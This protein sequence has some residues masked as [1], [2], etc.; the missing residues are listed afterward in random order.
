MSIEQWAHFRPENAEKYSR[1]NPSIPKNSTENGAK[2][3]RTYYGDDYKQTPI[4]EAF[5]YV[6]FMKILLYFVLKC[7]I[8]FIGVFAG[9]N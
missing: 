2:C 9:S 3:V 4:C 5:P 8:Y 6:S 1:K 7:N